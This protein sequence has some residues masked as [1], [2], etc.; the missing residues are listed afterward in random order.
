[1]VILDYFV[2]ST[3]TEKLQVPEGL[4]PSKSEIRGWL[5]S[6]LGVP[7]WVVLGASGPALLVYIL[8]FMETHIT[9][10]IIDKKD[11][12]LKKG[13][14]FHLDIVILC[15]LN[16]GCGFMG[17][18]WMCAATVRSI[19][20]VSAVTVMSRTHAPGDKPHIIDVKG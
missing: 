16:I 4:E 15:V 11:R 8:L 19:A 13:S 12:K 2:P 17:A 7:I 9:E 20:H 6:P 3:Y 5:I 14:G 10:L 18:P 1:M